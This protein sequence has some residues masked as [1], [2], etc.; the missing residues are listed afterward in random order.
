MSALRRSGRTLLRV[1]DA[2]SRLVYDGS[3]R[4]TTMDGTITVHTSAASGSTI[5]FTFNG[6]F[7][8]V[9]GVID[10]DA[11]TA[12]FKLDDQDPVTQGV[13][14]PSDAVLR[15]DWPFFSTVLPLHPGSH[16][17]TITLK[18]GAFSLDYIMYTALDGSNDS[19]GDPKVQVTSSSGGLPSSS[20]SGQLHPGIIAGAVVGAVLFLV[21]AVVAVIFVRRR[22]ARRVRHRRLD[23][24]KPI[25]IVYQNAPKSPPVAAHRSPFRQLSRV[26]RP[27]PARS[28]QSSKTTASS[29]PTSITQSSAMFTSVIML[30]P[31]LSM[32]SEEDHEHDSLNIV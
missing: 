15:P 7:V 21:G 10:G 3:W 9:Y 12:S 19:T 20:S 29:A 24:E 8:G 17:L 28:V 25:D 22:S 16:E 26:Y 11:V 2:S 5:K 27:T 6:T 32:V 30:S 13:P 14:R 23:S 18:E 31:A 1:D 4:S